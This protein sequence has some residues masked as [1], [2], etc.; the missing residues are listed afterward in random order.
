M[1]KAS[2]L[3]TYVENITYNAR[4]QR[5]NIYYGNG[6]KTKY[7]YDPE[8]KSV[9]T[10]RGVSRHRQHGNMTKMPHLPEMIW[11]YK[12]NFKE[13]DINSGNRVYYTYDA[14]GNRVRKIVIKNNGTIVEDR[15]YVNNYEI[16]R[17]TTNGTLNTF[18]FSILIFLLKS[19]IIAELLF[20]IIGFHF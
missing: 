4:M 2:T 19:I 13:A 1:Q 8:K 16:Y 20:Y 14:S 7:T 6:S 9:Q 12:D 3:E 17:K 18:S 10:R 11:D 15:I 5:T